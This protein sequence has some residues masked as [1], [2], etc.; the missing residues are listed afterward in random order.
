MKITTKDRAEY[1]FDGIKYYQEEL[2]FSAYAKVKTILNEKVKLLEMGQEQMGKV[3][4]ELHEKGVLADLINFLLIP[5][6]TLK[7]RIIYRFKRILDR[8]KHKKIAETM[9]AQQMAQVIADFFLLNVGWTTNFLVLPKE[10]DMK[11]MQELT[12]E[13]ISRLMKLSSEF[14]QAI[15]QEEVRSMN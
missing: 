12:K 4:D 14:A 11:L 3:L 7:N 13:N 15:S 2:N 10:L 9:T 5:D 1:I 6:K 8:N